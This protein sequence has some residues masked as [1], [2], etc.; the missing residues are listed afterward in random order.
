MKK[1]LQRYAEKE[2]GLLHDW[3]GNGYRRVLVIPCYR[4]N[5]HFLDRLLKQFA[6]QHLL[7]VLVVNRP[8]SDSDQDS[9]RELLE[10]IEKLSTP[11]WKNRHLD[12]RAWGNGCGLLLVNRSEAHLRLARKQ[13]VGL[14]RKI[15]CDIAAV[16]IESGFVESQW[17]HS[18]D[19]DARLPADYFHGLPDAQ[20]TAAALYPFAHD[21]GDSTTHRALQLYEEALHYYVDSLRSAGSPWAFHTIGSTVAISVRYY[22]A[23]RGFPK[24]SAGEDFYLLN[25]LA[26]LAPVI[27]LEKREPIRIAARLSD[28]VPFGTGPATARI[29]EILAAG[30]EP[31]GYAPQ[32]FNEL[33]DFLSSA[34]DAGEQLLDHHRW[35]AALEELGWQRFLDHCRR[36]KLSGA[37]KETA[38]RHWFDAF[39]T[40][41]FIHLMQRQWYPPQ[42]IRPERYRS[43]GSRADGIP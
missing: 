16:L 27:Q 19:A 35:R 23:A 38:F 34:L 29:A 28:R 24:R 7:L 43:S 14:A 36:Q 15:G 2:A 30:E 8:D 32:V 17:I 11:H 5:P 4:E 20:N 6:D 37:K 33:R 12:L 21:K 42:R 31:L 25:K 3:P 26:K 18:T 22:C 40:L 1:Y 13:G 39:R 10:A 9:N 41:R